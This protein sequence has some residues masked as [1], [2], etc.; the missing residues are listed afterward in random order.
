MENVALKLKLQE[1]KDKANKA[2]GY[3]DVLKDFHRQV[4]NL[5][6]E[7]RE[8]QEETQIS[9]DAITP[10]MTDAVRN[11]RSVNEYITSQ[12]EMITAKYL[13]EQMQRKVLYNKVQELRGNIRVFCRVRYDPRGDCVFKFASPTEMA[14]QNLQGSQTMVEFERCY[15]IK[16]SQEQVFDDTKPIILSCIDG[17]NVCIMAYGQTGMHLPLPP[18]VPV[19]QKYIIYTSPYPPI[20]TEINN[21]LSF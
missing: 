16:A 7:Q 10:I 6:R 5:K 8:T 4:L 19:S 9:I 20:G 17:Y 14:V 1:Y 13:Q 18:Y 2:S 15:D 21:H 3:V 12:L 11:I